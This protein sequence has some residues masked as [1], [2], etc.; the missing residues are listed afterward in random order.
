MMS[1]TFFNVPEKE[2]FP[3]I[4]KKMLDY[5][6]KIDAFQKQ[7]EITKGQPEYVFLDGPPF[8]SG[9]FKLGLP[10]FGNLLAGTVKDICTR[11]KVI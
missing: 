10:H 8:A 7:L 5:W 9:T 4:E 1:S 3:E 11:Y 6:T 2:N